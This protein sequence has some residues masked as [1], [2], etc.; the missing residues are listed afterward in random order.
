MLPA[1]RRPLFLHEVVDVVGE[2]AVPYM[3]HVVAFD[4]DRGADRGL[5]L[6]CTFQVVGSTARWPQVVNLWE[7]V[8]GWDGWRRLLRRAHTQRQSNAPLADWWREAYVHRSGGFDRLLGGDTTT[9]GLDTLVADGVGGELFVHEIATVPPGSA[10]AY[11]AS[12]REDRAPLLGAHGHELVG[13]YEVLTAP[14]E[15]I[16]LWATDI[17]S[18][19]ALAR[20]RD[21]ASGLDD[22]VDPDDALLRWESAADA[23]GARRREE[24]LV[25]LPGTP[26][27]GTAA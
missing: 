4:T 21:A 25:P 2:G 26:L 7:C 12:V 13:V 19:I 6:V 5:R 22:G 16:V 17:D 11:R 14:A 15:V 10:A 18:H 24:L 27:A 23:I 1:M 8:D 20:A 3:D 9:R